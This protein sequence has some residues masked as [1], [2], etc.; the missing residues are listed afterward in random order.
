MTHLGQE[1]RLPRILSAASP[2]ISLIKE[3]AM[4]EIA[5]FH[6]LTDG[7]RISDEQGF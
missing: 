3:L 2:A 5:M 7:F 6:Q 1:S 4:S